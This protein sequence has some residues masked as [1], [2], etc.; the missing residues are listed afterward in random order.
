MR[1]T[2]ASRADDSLRIVQYR[3][4]H[5]GKPKAT[6]A[7]PGWTA[8]AGQLSPLDGSGITTY[9]RIKGWGYS[10][11]TT[12]IA[13][14]S[15]AQGLLAPDRPFVILSYAEAQFLKGEAAALALGGSKTAEQYYYEGIDANFAFWKITNTAARDAYKARDGIKWGTTGS[16]FADFINLTRADIP[17][18]GLSKI[19]VQEWLNYFPDQAFDSWCLERRTRAIQF[20]PHT[21]PNNGV[22]SV[23]YMEIPLR[24]VYPANNIN[25]NPV[26]YNNALSQLGVQQVE[27]NPY[28]ALKFVK[29]YTVPDWNAKPARYNGQFIQKWYGTTI[30]DVTAAGISYNLLST[31]KP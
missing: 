14:Q 10:P 24:G 3:I 13:P 4:P 15:P 19:Y 12:I 8:T 26:G 21:N 1:D 20:L 2:L 22:V 28:I 30:Q 5:L 31:F 27:L 18:D 11:T 9:S 7:L 29:D 16:G 17:A 6:N 23:P 25:L